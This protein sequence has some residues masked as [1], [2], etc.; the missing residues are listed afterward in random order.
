MSIT[1]IPSAPG[2]LPILGHSIPLL[3]D[4]VGFVSSLPALGPLARLHVGRRSVVMVS[5]PN[6]AWHVLINDRIFDKGGPLYERARDLVGD[7]LAVCP[8]RLH[9]RLR[10]LC[11]PSFHPDRVAGYVP[12]IATVAEEMA[13][14]WHDGQVIDLHAEMTAFARRSVVETLF[15]ADALPAETERTLEEDLETLATGVVRK[16]LTPRSLDRL[17]TPFNRRYRRASQRLRRSL[18]ALVVT[19]RAADADR[20]DLL[21][22]LITAVDDASGPARVLTDEEVTD[23]IITFFGAGV[24]STADTLTWALLLLAGRPKVAVRLQS[25]GDALAAGRTPTVERLRALKDTAH[26]VAETLRLYPPGWLM[27]REVARPTELGGHHL[28][29]GTTVAWSSYLIHRHPGIYAHPDHFVPD[30]W[31]DLK[32]DRGTYLAFGG[33]A[34]K[35]IGDQVGLIQTT[36][37][38]AAISSRWR[39]EPVTAREPRIRA[40]VDLRP[41]DAH[42]RVRARRGPGSPPPGNVRTSAGDAAPT[43][44][45]LH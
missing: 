24:E 37:A 9:R 8:H 5:T 23:Q 16:A 6:L 19:R 33:G 7:G 3:R 15:T 21:S 18:I 30:R 29:P 40:G 36:L 38:L 45:A 44:S 43:G 35:C 28:V 20:G 12:R 34:R 4:P 1:S 22:R 32:P 11:Q 41:R 14:S 2:A 17:P 25:E 39:L 31:H 27:T 42:L 13:A 26:V 10:R